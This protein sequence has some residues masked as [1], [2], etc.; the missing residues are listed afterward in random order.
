MHYSCLSYYRVNNVDS[1]FE[2][3]E[4]QQIGLWNDA[5]RYCTCPDLKQTPPFDFECAPGSVTTC[6]RDKDYAEV[7]KGMCQVLSGPR[8]KSTVKMSSVSY[9]WASFRKH[10]KLK[11]EEKV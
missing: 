11:S 9:P 3:V 1:L 6:E 2:L 10:R 4:N 5:N 7:G 8:K